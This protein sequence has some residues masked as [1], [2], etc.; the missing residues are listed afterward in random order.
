MKL[1]YFSLGALIILLLATCIFVSFSKITQVTPQHAVSQREYDHAVERYS[2]IISQTPQSSEAY[3]NRGVI[4]SK[5]K[6][7]ELAAKDYAKAAELNPHNPEPLYNQACDHM[8]KQEWNE[9]IKLLNK[10]IELS[11]KHFR[12]LHC[13]ALSYEHQGK[14]DQAGTDYTAALQLVP[15][16]AVFYLNCLEFQIISGDIKKFP[17]TM[18]LFKQNVSEIKLR[19]H[20]RIIREYLQ[21]IYLIV[22]GQP[23]DQQTAKVLGML[24]ATQLGWS[25]AD[26]ERWLNS[27]ANQLPPNSKTAIRLLTEK[28][29]QKPQNIS[30]RQGMLQEPSGAKSIGNHK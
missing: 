13:R 5:K 11:P 12:A 1:I 20:Q 21:A 24:Q 6:E 4:Y 8:R 15:K 25:F 17:A 19:Q 3:N 27:P 2:A 23:A 14:F 18:E 28:L 26:I 7:Y 29:Q 10:T 9:A 16:D 22:T 30:S